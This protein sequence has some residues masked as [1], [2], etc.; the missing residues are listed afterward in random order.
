MSHLWQLGNTPTNIGRFLVGEI[1]GW[2]GT[3]VKQSG[4]IQYLFLFIKQLVKRILPTSNPCHQ[5]GMQISRSFLCQINITFLWTDHYLRQP[6][7][8]VYNSIP[9]KRRE[10]RSLAESFETSHPKK[11]RLHVEWIILGDRTWSN[12]QKLNHCQVH[13]VN[14][15]NHPQLRVYGISLH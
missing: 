14:P 5:P 11:K 15:I 10:I 9:Q 2:F 13:E 6:P 1:A 3:I 12:H 4:L 8:Q 7:F